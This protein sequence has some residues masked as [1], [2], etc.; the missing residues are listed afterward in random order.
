MTNSARDLL[1]ILLSLGVVLGCGF[2]AGSLVMKQRVAEV[3]DAPPT[4]PLAE[5]EAESLAALK[6]T[7][8]LSPEQE[9]AIAGDLEAF[10]GD[11]FDTRQR[12]VL[13]YH[14]H[15]LR[16]HDE[17][18]PKLDPDQQ[19]ILRRNRERLQETIERRFST[20]P[21]EESK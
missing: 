18:L 11:V 1:L 21:A 10:G 15:L 16:L 9:Q 3:E 14:T 13:E 12:A 5:L 8:G 19:K 4:V 17:L 7:L 2:A 20:T 6:K